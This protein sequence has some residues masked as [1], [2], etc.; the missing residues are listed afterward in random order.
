MHVWSILY[1]HDACLKRMILTWCMCHKHVIPLWYKDIYI[2]MKPLGQTQTR[3][4]YN[5]NTLVDTSFLTAQSRSIPNPMKLYNMHSS[6]K[7]VFLNIWHTEYF[8]HAHLKFEIYRISD[9]LLG[10][11]RAWFVIFKTLHTCRDLWFRDPTYMPWFVISRPLGVAG[12]YRC[13]NI[14]A[15]MHT[16]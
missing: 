9:M 6:S 13:I 3:Q 16:Q 1:L 5:T 2:Y 7:Y 15:H 12:H 8:Q 14:Q 10:C 4:L 11:P